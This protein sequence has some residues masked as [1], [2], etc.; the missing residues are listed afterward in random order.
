MIKFILATLAAEKLSKNE[1]VK[2]GLDKTVELAVKGVKKT[3]KE[4]KK[5]YEN[6]EKDIHNLKEKASKEFKKMKG[7]EVEIS[8]EDTETPPDIP[9]EVK[10]NM[11][12]ND[13]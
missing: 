9:T 4:A 10:D 5:F 3:T 8:D 11:E 12:K 1:T 7:E 13:D 6:H 2:K